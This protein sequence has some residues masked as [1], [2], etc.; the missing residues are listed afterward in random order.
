MPDRAANIPLKIKTKYL[1]ATDLQV[2]S[3]NEWRGSDDSQRLV[4]G[5]GF[6]V[7]PHGLKEGSIRDEEDDERDEDAVEQADEKVLVVEHW[8]LL[9]RQVE[10][11]E[12][13]TQFVINIL[14]W[15]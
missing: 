5:G 14:K 11:G 15:E 4:V 13:Q 1:C 7:L 10:L 3:K 8:P 2:D 6:S 9:A 12:F